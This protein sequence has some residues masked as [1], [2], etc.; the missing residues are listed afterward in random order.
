M[1][2]SLVNLYLYEADEEHCV[3]T[4]EMVGGADS[5]GF[6]CGDLEILPFGLQEERI[7]RLEIDLCIAA[8][9]QLFRLS[10]PKLKVVQQ[11][12]FTFVE[13]MSAPH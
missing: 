11:F 13:K 1:W 6:H 7:R 10:L 12:S 4:A 5:F 9:T 8:L 2:G 3:T